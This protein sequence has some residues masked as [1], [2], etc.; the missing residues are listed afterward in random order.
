MKI[1]VIDH[2][3]IPQGVA[4]LLHRIVP[5]HEGLAMLESSTLESGLEYC[6][7]HDD[8]DLVVLDLVLPDKRG[9]E[10]LDT[11]LER[12]P[13]LHVAVMFDAA[14][15]KLAS[16]ALQHGAR[17]CIPK[18]ATAEAFVATLQALLRG[19]R[20]PHGIAPPPRPAA[21]LATPTGGIRPQNKH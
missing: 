7:Q 2:H 21:G 19:A 16:E 4:P 11:L 15:P 1:L 5:A 6:E 20:R 17:A 10:A 18:P 14:Q 3:D 9:M 8:L 13:R 12:H